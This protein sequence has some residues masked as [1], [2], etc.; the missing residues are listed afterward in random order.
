LSFCE[1]TQGEENL[2]ETRL[3][4]VQSLCLSISRSPLR[5]PRM[6]ALLPKRRLADRQT[7]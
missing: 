7:N 2:A 5:P 3:E 4:A 6:A 1:I